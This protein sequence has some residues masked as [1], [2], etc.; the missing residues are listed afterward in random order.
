VSRSFYPQNSPRSFRT[1][2]LVKEFARKGHEVTVITPKNDEFH[3]PFELA[4]NIV[5]KDLGKLRFKD[6]DFLSGGKIF[7]LLKRVL[8]RGLN[9]LFDYPDIELFFLVKK[10]LKNERNYDLLISIAAPHPVHWG[11]AWAW[12]KKKG[13]AK[14]WIA[15]C[16]DPF[17]GVSTDTFRKLFYF[18]YIEKYWCKNTNYISVP[19]KGAVD[20]YYKEYHKKIKIIPQGFN[21]EEIE[22]PRDAYKP[23]QVLTF[24]YAGGLIPGARDAKKFIEYLLTTEID[25]KFILYTKSTNMILPFIETAK[26]KIE[27]RDYIPREKLLKKLYK[28]DFIINFNNGVMTQLPSKLI[29]YYL[30][31]RPVLSLD[32]YNFDKRVVDQ[33]LNRNYSSKFVFENPEKYRIENVTQQFLDLNK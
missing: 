30:T 17:M 15:D 26:G 31:K 7:I 10:A 11:V 14:T 33:F 12:N 27:V 21:F 23:N 3:I 2:E 8:R 25:F 18:K 1:T 16:G 4:N 9:L 19:F 13:I 32:S 5:I 28:M 24:A 20:G 22:V 6:I 29:D